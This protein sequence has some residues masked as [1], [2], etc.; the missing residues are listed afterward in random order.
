MSACVCGCVRVYVHYFKS[1]LYHVR[2]SMGYICCVT[3]EQQCFHKNKSFMLIHI[4]L[5]LYYTFHS[6]R[7]LV[8]ASYLGFTGK[9]EGK[10]ADIIY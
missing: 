6:G 3:W 7:P 8:A 2:F 1:G 5:Q 9:S 10:K 4:Y